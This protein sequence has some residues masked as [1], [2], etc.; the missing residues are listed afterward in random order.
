MGAEKKLV[1]IEYTLGDGGEG[2]QAQQVVGMGS[3][4]G[5]GLA[6]PDTSSAPLTAEPGTHPAVSRPPQR[7]SLEC[8]CGWLIT[9]HKSKPD[10]LACVYMNSHTNP[11]LQ[12]KNETTICN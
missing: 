12:I 6:A 4:E 3:R 11:L 8:G 5:G 7:G 9:P 1:V 10:L 2:N